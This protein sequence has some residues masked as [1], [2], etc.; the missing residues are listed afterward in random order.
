MVLVSSLA[1]M[2]AC[3]RLGCADPAGEIAKLIAVGV[4]GNAMG[5]KSD[6]PMKRGA[7]AN[8]PG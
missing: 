2:I 7:N 5:S 1:T 3:A 6:R 4:I 8:K